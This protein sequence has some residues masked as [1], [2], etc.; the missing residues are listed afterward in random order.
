LCQSCRVYA[1]CLR[2]LSSPSLARLMLYYIRSRLLSIKGW[3]SDPSSYLSPTASTRCCNLA[4]LCIS[5][6]GLT[7]CLTIESI[8][9]FILRLLQRISIF[10]S[11][12]HEFQAIDF[13][14]RFQCP[15][16]TRIPLA[17]VRNYGIYFMCLDRISSREQLSSSTLL[18]S[19]G[20]AQDCN[21]IRSFTGS[22]R[23]IRNLEARGSIPRGETILLLYSAIVYLH[24]WLW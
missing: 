15:P 20:R 2:I 17:C 12:E 14:D 22:N 6:C 3:I 23:I 16:S 4:F 5:L 21:C 11:L 18:S 8:I 9:W 13:G 1:C 19:A 7:P 24:F 10:Q